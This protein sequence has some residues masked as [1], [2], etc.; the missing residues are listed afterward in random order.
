MN[1]FRLPRTDQRTAVFG[2][3]GS[4]KTVF[5]T[6]L[7]SHAAFD[8]QPYIIVDY[9]GDKL[10]GQTGAVEIGLKERIPK[11][12]GLFIVHPRPKTDDD[13]MEAFLWKVWAQE[14]VG[15]F[16]DEMYVL[17]NK[18]ALQAILTQGRSKHL[19]AIC[20]SQRPVWVSRMVTS[21]A[22]FFAIFRLKH[23][24]DRKTVDGFV[25][26]NVASE[27]LT[28]PKYH[29]LWY[30]VGEDATFKMLPAPS[31]DSILDRFEERLKPKR[32]SW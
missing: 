27:V 23:P 1:K 29:S 31:E 11:R 19:P 22:D 8:Q 13:E 26:A 30:D 15:L 12:P 14:D 21:E 25:G 20:L 10:L 4:G 28:L 32:K 6:W 7:L 17:P 9:K 16:F 24:D 5:G 18:G 2:R 3:T